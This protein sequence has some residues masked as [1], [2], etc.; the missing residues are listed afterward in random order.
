MRKHYVGMHAFERRSKRYKAG[1]YPDGIFHPV[2]SATT[3][4]YKVPGL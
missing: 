2:L 1:L 3:L 4:I